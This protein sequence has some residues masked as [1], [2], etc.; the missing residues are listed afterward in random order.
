[1]LMGTLN[2]TN[3][4]FHPN[5][6]ALNFLQNYSKK[7]QKHSQ[8]HRALNTIQS[9][10][11]ISSFT[12]MSIFEKIFKTDIKLVFFVISCLKANWLDQ[13]PLVKIKHANEFKHF[14]SKVKVKATN[15]CSNEKVRIKVEHINELKHFDEGVKIKIKLTNEFEHFDS[16]LEG[17]VKELQ[18]KVM[19][20]NNNIKI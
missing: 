15:E 16:E 19:C 1:M 17:K 12:Y 14:H 6:G 11:L 10:I 20:Q 9:H 4:K 7:I 3:Y 13:K 5:L 8:I 18:S 2:G